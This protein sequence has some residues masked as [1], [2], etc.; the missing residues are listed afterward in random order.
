MPG[1]RL[2]RRLVTLLV[3][4][5]IGF[6]V[7]DIAVSKVAEGRIASALQSRY[8][9]RARP[10]VHLGGFPIL[11]HLWRRDLPSMSIAIHSYAPPDGPTFDTL[12]LGVRGV[13]LDGS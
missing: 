1:F 6:V 12:T 13:K 4:L 9:L 2:V 8:H 10:T 11:L 3:V 7:A 5:A